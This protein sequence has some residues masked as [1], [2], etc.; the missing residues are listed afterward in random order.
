MT[1]PA[2][3]DPS[4]PSQA[5][6]RSARL[7]A[8]TRAVHDTLDQGIMAADIFASRAQ[9]GRFVRVQHRF[10]RDIEALYRQPALNALLPGLAERCRLPAIVQDLHDLQPDAPAPATAPRLSADTPLPV[11]LGWLYVAEGSNMGGAVLFKM[12]SDKLGLGRDFGARHLAPH[13]DGPARHWR[14]FTAM[15]DAVP[16]DAAQEAQLM[17]AAADAFATVQGYAREE[18]A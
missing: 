2:A 13:P 10:H 4:H 8:A 5:E 17:Q 1:D 11:A 18:M 3:K 7:K 15:L 16:L 9:F 14:E 12:A 6:G